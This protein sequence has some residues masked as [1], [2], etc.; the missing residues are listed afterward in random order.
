MI[1]YIYA[2]N[3][4]GNCIML[5]RIVCRFILK[6]MLSWQQ[7]NDR[8]M[9]P[10]WPWLHRGYVVTSVKC[11]HCLIITINIKMKITSTRFQIWAHE[12]FVEWAPNPWYGVFYGIIPL[13]RYRLTALQWR[14]NERDSVSK[15]Q[16]LD[17]VFNRLLTRI[18]KK[19]SKFRTTGF[20]EGN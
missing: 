6:N 1:S 12:N 2:I 3:R 16:R 11:W 19:T 15:H 9:S 13:F 18:S 14:H 10:F 8:I 7:T 4:R 20:T 5:Y 17:R